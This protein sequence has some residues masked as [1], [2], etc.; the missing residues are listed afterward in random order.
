[1]HNPDSDCVVSKDCIEACFLFNGYHAV[2]LRFQRSLSLS[3]KNFT[4]T[5]RYAGLTL[6]C[7]ETF[8]AFAPNN[9]SGRTSV[10][11]KLIS[12]GKHCGTLVSNPISS[13]CEKTN[14]VTTS[15]RCKGIV[16]KL[17]RLHRQILA[18]EGVRG[19]YHDLGI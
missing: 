15:K 9:E 2:R 12:A 7:Y 4:H 17:L 11:Y 8:K 14:G 5:H 1:M 13:Y 6:M 18:K 3:I 19:F 16:Q 10:G